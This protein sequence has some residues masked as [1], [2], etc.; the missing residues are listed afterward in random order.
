M[1][2]ANIPSGT[3]EVRWRLTCARISAGAWDTAGKLWTKVCNIA[4]TTAAGVPW[5]L[6]SPTTA[7]Q[8]WASNWT[9]S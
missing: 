3:I 2:V 7:P 9:T 8:W 4:M 5:P 6:T 1:A